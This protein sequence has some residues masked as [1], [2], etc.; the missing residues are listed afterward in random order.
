MDVFPSATLS[1][2]VFHVFLPPYCFKWYRREVQNVSGGLLSGWVGL[3][4]SGSRE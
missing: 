1:P 3:A 4:L 2:V